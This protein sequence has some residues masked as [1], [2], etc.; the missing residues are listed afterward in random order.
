MNLRNIRLIVPMFIFIGTLSCS[1]DNQIEPSPP[2]GYRAIESSEYP[3]DWLQRRE[4]YPTPD[5][6]TGDYDGDGKN[7]IARMWINSEGDSCVITAY[8]SNHPADPKELVRS[9]RSPW[10]FM[11]RTIPPGLHKTDR[12]YGIGPGGPDSTAVIQTET[13]SIN[14]VW[15]ESEG[16]VFIWDKAEQGFYRVAMY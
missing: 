14:W 13:D 7:D 1:D 15:M 6:A 11:I 8:L 12:F 9:A 16:H 3:E 2:E 5:R 10:R 4:E